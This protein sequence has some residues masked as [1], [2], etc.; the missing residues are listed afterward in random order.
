[1]CHVTLLAKI[2]HDRTHKLMENT[3]VSFPPNFC[4]SSTMN[5]R[6]TSYSILHQKLHLLLILVKDLYYLELSK[7]DSNINRLINRLDYNFKF[8]R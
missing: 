4:S 1:M 6:E 2:Y 8:N 3:K 5:S 7:S